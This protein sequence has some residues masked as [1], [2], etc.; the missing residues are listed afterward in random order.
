MK[1][2]EQGVKR[3]QVLIVDQRYGYPVQLCRALA[4]RGCEV[5]G[6]AERGAPLLRSRYCARRIASPPWYAG[7]SFRALLQHT[8]ERTAYDVIYVCSEVILETM[9]PVI[10]SS[11]A[12]A[13]LPRPAPDALRRVFSKNAVMRQVVKWD[14]PVPHSV[15]PE[16]EAD[17][18]AFVRQFDGPIVV[19]G[20]KGG[21]AQHVRIARTRDEVL[22]FW[23][24]IKR[25]E[26][27]Y[28]GMPALQEFVPG[29]TYLVGAVIDRGRVVRMAAHKK[30]LMFPAGGGTTVRAVTERHDALV[31]ATLAAFEALEYTGIADLDFI[32]DARTGEFRFLEINPRPWASIG[33]ALEAT[34]LLTAYH[35]IARGVAVEPDLDYRT[36]LVYHRLSGELRLMCE[37]PSRIP[38][39]IKDCLSPGVMSDFDPTDLWPHFATG[40]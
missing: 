4:R 10:E 40:V 28:D 2:T 1:T 35:D 9:I 18:Q 19:K 30:E 23:R 12:W 14:V 6:F 37:R 13:A 3:E 11:A 27:S 36:G 34:D 25:L 16:D 5:H 21:A 38:G 26:Q 15:V 24:E 7:E 17:V 8:V 33:L 22:P 29:D 31:A 39:F 32:R 20:E